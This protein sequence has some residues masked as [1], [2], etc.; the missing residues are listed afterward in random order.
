MTKSKIETNDHR[1]NEKTEICDRKDQII[2]FLSLLESKTVNS[3]CALRILETFASSKHG[4]ST[5][6]LVW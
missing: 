3:G 1:L 2:S 4:N 6:W 5:I